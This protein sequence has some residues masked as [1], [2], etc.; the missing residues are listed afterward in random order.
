MRLST[1]SDY[2]L[3][4][5]MYLGVQDDR[6]VTIAEIAAVHGISKSHLMKVVH[7]LGLNGHIETVRGKGGGMRLARA[8]REIVVGDVIRQSESDFALAECFAASATCR[9]Q[10]ACCLPAI[11]NEALSAMFLVLDGYTLADLL[12]RPHGLVPTAPCALF[13]SQA[14]GAHD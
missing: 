8:P 9:I 2:S 1:F 12:K 7:Q 11:L 4:V 10:G 13:A 3:R 14:D 6:L 5:L